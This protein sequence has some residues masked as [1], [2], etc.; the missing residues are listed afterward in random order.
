LLRKKKVENDDKKL[1][2]KISED[3]NIKLTKKTINFVKG[4]T[5]NQTK[6]ERKSNI[7]SYCPSIVKSTK[8][9]M[10]TEDK[11]YALS[12]FRERTTYENVRLFLAFF[13]DQK[14]IC[15][16]G[17]TTTN[18]KVKIDQEGLPTNRD[19]LEKLYMEYHDK[20]GIPKNEAK[21]D[22]EQCRNQMYNGY[23]DYLGKVREN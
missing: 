10:E 7:D 11:T 1:T 9:S 23:R 5:I 19:E 3:Q 14:D 17:L 12:R 20:I 22:L 13:H 16:M 2:E 6:Q 4:E 15:Y 21:T 8:L 18:L